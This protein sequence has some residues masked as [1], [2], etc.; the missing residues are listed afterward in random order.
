MIEI[1]NLHKSFGSRNVLNGLTFNVRDRENLVVIGLSGTGKSILLKNMVG[2]IK[3][4]SGSIIVDG[5][6]ITKCSLAQLRE[7]QKKMG[8][9]FQEAALFDSLTIYENVAFGLKNLSSMPAS[10]IG[11]RVTECLAMVGLKSDIEKLKPSSLSG[12][13]KKRAA[14]ARTIAYSPRYIFYD[15]PTTGLDPIMSDVISDLIIH[16]R[17]KLQITSVAVS[18]DMKSAHKM[19][20]RIIMLYQGRI[21][22]D[23]T[24]TEAESTDN[25]T[26]RQFVEGSAQGPIEAERTFK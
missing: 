11:K 17:D 21:V 3:P 26:V 18:H 13:M 20:D 7:T 2:L 19:A 6:D 8:Y 1:K 9:V 23:G 5:V 22:F 4:T 16:L 12:G 24:P 10:Q 25:K 15:E 14:I